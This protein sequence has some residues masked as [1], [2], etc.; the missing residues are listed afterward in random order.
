MRACDG[1]VLAPQ[2]FTIN[3]DAR[4]EWAAL[5]RLYKWV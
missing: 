2:E 1:L 5:P 3:R 4:L